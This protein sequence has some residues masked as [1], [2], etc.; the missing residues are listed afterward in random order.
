MAKFCTK[1]GNATDKCTCDKNAPTQVNGQTNFMDEVK[2]VLNTMVNLFKNPEKAVK[3]NATPKA[4]IINMIFQ[5]VAIFIVVSL[6]IK[7]IMGLISGNLLMGSLFGMSDIEIPF[8]LY[9]KLLFVSASISVIFLFT[10][11]T[12]IYLIVKKDNDYMNVIN[13]VSYISLIITVTMLVT[14]V[15]SYIHSYLLALAFLSGVIY[16]VIIAY[17]YIKE[18]FKINSSKLAIIVTTAIVVTIAVGGFVSNKLISIILS[19]M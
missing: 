13:K 1:C 8:S 9:V 7:S 18:N 6:S 3:E 15:M 10:F 19:N 16:F 5:T 12:F 17:M 14:L 2:R 4:W 11:G